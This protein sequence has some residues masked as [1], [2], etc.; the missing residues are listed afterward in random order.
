MS[1]KKQ[2]FIAF[3]GNPF[4]DSRITNLK[5]SLEDNF[6][7]VKVIGF[8]WTTPKF[9]TYRDESTVVYKLTK[10]KF[11]IFFYASFKL[12]LLKELFK[13]KADLY[14]AEEI[15]SLPFVK[16]RSYFDNA[17]VYY[18]SRELY[19]FLGGLRNRKFIQKIF[20]TLERIFIHKVDLVLTTGEMD[21][22]FLHKFYGIKNTLVIRNIP[23]FTRVT[24]KVDLR[25]KLSLPENVKILLY[26]G[27]LIDGRGI[28]LV[29]SNLNNI[30][31]SVLV[32]VGDGERKLKW[33]K[34]AEE[35]NVADRVF[36]LGTIPQEELINYTAAGDIGVCLIENISVSYY[37]ALPNKLFEYIMAGLPVISSA[38]P[39][40]KNIVEKYNVGKVVDLEVSQRIDSAINEMINDQEKL[41]VYK[42]N[43]SLAAQELNW[44]V[45]FSNV[46]DHLLNF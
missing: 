10:T 15:Y 20:T 12:L 31:N 45:E 22:E 23:K 32:L 24:D 21:S 6:C 41:N 34:Y 26:Q 40:M 17:K 1:K 39:Q 29:I 13:T 16:F 27:V 9:K 44:D 18:N 42:N 19:A 36:F 2:I 46:K 35:M 43:C 37:H 25:K 38:L 7:D 8:D 28:E 30:P 11:S 3:L 4:H 5:K 14:F 33:Q